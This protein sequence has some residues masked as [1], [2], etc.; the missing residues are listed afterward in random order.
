MTEAAGFWTAYFREHPAYSRIL[1]EL[2]QKYRK[3][4]YPAGVIRLE[5]ASEEEIGRAHV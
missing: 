1:L 4:G 3:F 2:R 5:D